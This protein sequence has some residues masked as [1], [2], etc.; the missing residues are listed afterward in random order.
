MVVWGKG[1]GASR[2]SADLL[3]HWQQAFAS[4]RPCSLFRAFRSAS[5]PLMARS[6]FSGLGNLGTVPAAQL[7]SAGSFL[8]WVLRRLQERDARPREFRSLLQRVVR[9]LEALPRQDR[10]RWLELLS[11]IHA[12]VYHV[13]SEEE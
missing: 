13:R 12:L 1:A 6:L 5:E 4:H 7:E 3:N 2:T 9:H 11:Y 8:G 10:N